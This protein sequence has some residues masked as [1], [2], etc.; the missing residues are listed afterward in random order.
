M[1]LIYTLLKGLFKIVLVIFLVVAGFFL[2]WNWPV[3][4]KN[5][6]MLFGVSFSNVFAREMGLDWKQVYVV[7]LDDLKPKRIRLA[8]YWTEI[9]KQKGQYDFSDL[10]WQLDEARKR[11][12]PV[13]LAFGIKAPRWP[14]C[15]IPE[16]YKQDKQQREDALLQYENVL[17]QRYKEYD[18]IRVWQVENEPFLDFGDC[19]DGAV[20]AA[21]VDREIAAVKK[22]D[23]LRPVMV[24][25]SGELSL[26]YQAAKRGDMFGST[27]YRNI[28]KEPIGYFTY[29]IGP[30]FFRMKA[31]LIRLFAFQENMIIAELQA[32]PWG[33][34]SIQ[35]MTVAEQYQSM[36]PQIFEDIVQYTKKT[37]FLEAYFWGVEWWYWLK[38]NQNDAAMWESARKVL[39]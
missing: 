36:N 7:M 4:E 27:L 26:W 22:Y 33:P 2:I 23:K 1:A 35:Q 19:I 11:K 37:N 24:T 38:E 18:N 16:F 28:Y 15:H 31:E 8:A 30:N 39:K 9:E 5:D 12:V 13:I 25:D 10:D 6:S 17:I 32:E 21:L 3:S 29:P 14:E 34:K 20:D